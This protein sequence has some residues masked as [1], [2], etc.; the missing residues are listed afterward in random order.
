MQFLPNVFFIFAGSKEQVMRDIFLS[1]KRPFYQSTQVINM[2]EIDKQEYYSFAASHFGPKRP[3]DQE[4]FS[5]IY[6]TFEGHTWYIQVILNRLYT[7]NEQKIDT[8]LVNNIVTE[9]IEELAYSFE[10]LLKSSSTVAI[11]LLKAI[12][13]E[14]CVKEINS[15]IFIAT[16]GLKAAS[17]INT[18]LKRL[19]HKEII[20]T[21]PKGY[22]I[23]DRFMAIWL[24]LQS[25]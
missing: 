6:D 9:I 2:E 3:F 21:T 7:C 22:I 13:K 17:S 11:K 5:Q 14:Q 8:V 18:A 4:I 20:Y 1:P 25:L 10:R 12:A 19:I 16:Y 24:R 15:G 23:H